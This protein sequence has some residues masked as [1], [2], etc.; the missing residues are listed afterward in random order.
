MGNADQSYTPGESQTYAEDR[1]RRLRR[2]RVVGYLVCIALWL[3]S[4]VPLARLSSDEGGGADVAAAFLAAGLALAVVSRGI[5][6]WR[7]KR[8]FWSPWLFVIAAV[9]AITSYGVQSAGEEP[10]R[11]AGASEG[12]ESR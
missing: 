10:F 11:P 2:R 3:L 9:L 6:A 5:Y 4:A 8:P 1:L 12:A 7:R